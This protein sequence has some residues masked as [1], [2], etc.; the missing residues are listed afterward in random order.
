MEN[1]LISHSEVSF[2]EN[3][4]QLYLKNKDTVELNVLGFGEICLVIGFPYENS[5]Y[6]CK[7]LPPFLDRN[8]AEQYK[9]YLLNYQESLIKIGINI[10]LSQ[11]VIIQSNKDQYV[12]Y[13]IQPNISNRCVDL[14]RT[15]SRNERTKIIKSI[16]DQIAMSCSPR[17]AIDG[18][19]SNWAWLDGKAFLFDLSTPFMKDHNLNSMLNVD[20][21]L[22]Q[23]PSIIKPTLRKWVVPGV[24]EKYHILRSNLIDFIGN[25]YKEGLEESIPESIEIAN[26][27]LESKI[28]MNEV[29]SYY[30][31]DAFLW[32]FIYLLKKI[33]YWWITTIRKTTCNFLISPPTDRKIIKKKGKVNV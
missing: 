13:I 31:M 17:L 27:Y 29:Y 23:Y 24:L 4:I 1:N 8:S 16:F 32:E 22:N 12:I 18:Q 33:N 15:S 3:Q 9:E 26:S 2:L 20:I 25:L 10:L 11:V 30:R 28:S 7:R 19:L 5:K 14:I 21:I 6:A